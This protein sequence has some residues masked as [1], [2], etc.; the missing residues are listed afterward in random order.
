MRYTPSA[1]RS[2]GTRTA[3]ACVSTALIATVAVVAAC[4]D[5]TPTPTTAPTPQPA[6]TATAEPTAT[7]TAEA[8]STPVPTATATASPTATATL[9]PSSTAT[10]IPTPTATSTATPT[11]TPSLIPTGTPTA[12][13]SSGPEAQ[14]AA[15]V[16][17]FAATDGD[18]WTNN[19]GWLSDLPLDQ[20]H[21]VTTDGRGK[22]TGLQLDENNLSGTIPAV[23]GQLASLE[24]L[25][26]WGNQ[27]TGSIPPQIGRLTALTFLDL[28][29][30]QLTG[31]VPAEIG[32]L[33]ALTRLSLDD[34]RLTGIIPPEL[35]NL[36]RLETLWLAHN[37]LTGEIPESLGYL[38][39]LESISFYE[40][41]FEGCIPDTMRQ[42]DNNDFSWLGLL[43]CGANPSNPDDRAVLVKLY[44]ATNGDNWRNNDGWLS[45]LPL[46][47]WHGVTTDGRGNVT[48]LWLDEN[49]LS[50][51][52]PAEIGALEALAIL[53][54]TDNQL[55]GDIPHELWRLTSLYSLYLSSNNLTGNI[56]TEIGN[57]KSLQDLG[58]SW[59]DISGTIP[60]EIWQLTALTQLDLQSNNLT[61]T[62]P[63]EIG[64]LMQLSFLGLANNEFTGSIPDEIGRLTGLEWV[65]VSG[66]RFEGCIPA[67]LRL[68]GGNDIDRLY[69][70]YCG[71]N[72]SVHDDRA[73][74]VKL[75]NATDGDN[76]INN[77]GWLTELPLYQWH[78][79]DVNYHGRVA[80]LNLGNNN[81]E[82]ALIPEIGNLRQ[83][84]DLRLTSN[85]LSGQL[86]VEIAE[87]DKLRGLHLDYNQLIGTIP[88]V[89][90]DLTNL[91]ELSL[92]GNNLS[93][94]IPPE[95][96]NLVNLNVLSL[97][98]NKLT[99]D[100]PEWVKDLRTLEHLDLNDNQLTGDISSLSENLGHLTTF[101]VS[102]NNLSGCLHETLRDIE[103]TD[104]IFSSLNYCDEPPKRPPIT[105]E[106]IKWEVGVAVRPVEELAA[107]RGVQWLFEYAESIGWPIVGNDITVYFMTPEPLAYAAAIEDGTIDEGEIE[108]ELESISG[109]GGFAREDSNFNKASEEGESINKSTLYR[110]AYILIHENL[111]T[112]FQYDI[113]GLNTNPASVQRQG[114]LGPAWF[115][116]GMATYF[117]ELIT[118]LHTGETDFLCRDCE[119]G[120]VKVS[121]IALTDDI[122]CP[123]R[124]GALAIE[125]LASIV[126]QRH[127][128]DFYTMRRPGQ[129]W[130][131]TFE[132]AFD[133]SVPDFYALYDQHRAAGFPKLNPPVVPETGR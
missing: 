82:G 14:R 123:Y 73:V 32:N 53:Y 27:L 106:F 26:L 30:N 25:D 71:G 39:K 66:N 37:E 133:I 97:N 102:G 120:E 87:L 92:S 52:I 78:G 132:E 64:N 105:P 63:P 68:V 116:E 24:H 104:F 111:H 17:F 19:E 76:W 1:T 31:E 29:L 60:K 65:F 131:E 56:P 118:S 130:Q 75:Y 79:V 125:L 34:N 13:D 2:G 50:G 89:I 121:D 127:I 8:T 72:P 44:N 83:L 96:S 21:G 91:Q 58:L 100:L 61:G 9:T 4:T 108:S 94:A 113:N 85:D 43:F 77:E 70:R 40:N 47:Q 117:G 126:G 20:W 114:E 57:L 23:V 38:P 122:Y 112:A 115:V 11:P 28:S 35:G 109:I 18:N 10:P 110:V 67:P 22:I 54:L 42:I 129:T 36:K 16:A 101:W 80:R 124:C 119:I 88:A 90:G 98:S 15:L 51:T 81:L 107:I 46:D 95:L 93:G 45:D 33:T 41:E 59:N 48:E 49:N 62:I 86:P 69:L 3:L 5:S 12:T 103:E 6:S 99:G 74:L 7:A 128:V 55:V 84:K